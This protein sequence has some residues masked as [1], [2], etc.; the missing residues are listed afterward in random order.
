A[1]FALG[2]TVNDTTMPRLKSTIIAGCANNK[3]AESLHGEIIREKGFLYAPD[4]V[5]NGGGVSNVYYETAPAGYC[6]EASTPRVVGS[7]AA[8][9]G[10]FGRS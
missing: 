8:R 10:S 9:R 7:F 4:Y 3:L 1:E 2:A 6:G 5:I